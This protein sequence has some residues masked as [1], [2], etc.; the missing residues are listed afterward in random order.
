MPDAMLEIIAAF[1]P[2]IYISCI[3][4]AKS[5]ATGQ[6]I[7]GYLFS[8]GATPRQMMTHSER[9]TYSRLNMAARMAERRGARI[10]G[11]GAFTSVV[12]DAGI[13]V[14]RKANIA[15][16][17]G[18]SLTVAVTL[19]TSRQ[20]LSK[21]GAAS[22]SGI[23]AMI[24]GATGSIG[25][26]CARMLAQMIQEVTLV[27]VELGSLEELKWQ[28]LAETPEARIAL[29]TVADEHLANCDLIISATSAI[30]QRVIDISRCKSGVVVCDVAM[31]ADISPQEAATRPDILVVESGAVVFPGE[32]DI[33]FDMGL[34]PNTTYACL[35][36]TALLAMEGCFESFTL[37]RSISVDQVSEIFGLFQ[38]HGFQ[39]AGL[40][41]FGKYVTDEEIARKRALTDQLREQSSAYREAEK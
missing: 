6:R 10:M 18:N 36:E 40:R 34:P 30:G 19:A 25:S 9:F 14:A 41:S 5:P 22:M 33:G 27:S 26:V 31:P 2:P 16:T 11:L 24:I 28:I 39:L 21:M 17:T 23:K 38:K 20:A 32:V 35:A 29:S 1:Y 13:S 4:G 37:G 3:K 7:E 12:G 15:I 8:L